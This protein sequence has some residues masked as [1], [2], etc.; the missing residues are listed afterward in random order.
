VQEGVVE[1]EPEPVADP[2]APERVAQVD[3]PERHH[4]PSDGTESSDETPAAGDE[5]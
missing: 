2:L 3:A 5:E 4:Q 1:A